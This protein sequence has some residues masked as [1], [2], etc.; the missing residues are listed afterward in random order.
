MA[1]SIFK[2]TIQM[3]NVKDFL[4]DVDPFDFKGEGDTFGEAIVDLAGVIGGHTGEPLGPEALADVFNTGMDAWVNQL[5]GAPMFAQ[6]REFS[7][8]EANFDLSIFENHRGQEVTIMSA[9]ASGGR[10]Q[11]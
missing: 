5:T 1:K 11:L 8:P 9:H 4:D 3:T 2:Y 7:D 6:R 10:S